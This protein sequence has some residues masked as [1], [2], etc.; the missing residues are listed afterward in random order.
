MNKKKVYFPNL[1]GLRFIAAFLVIIH[2]I[3]QLKLKFNLPNKYENPF[4]HISGRLGVLLFFVLSGFLITYLLLSE[5]EVTGSIA[6]KQFYIRRIL[7]IWPLYYLVVLLGLFVL[8]EISILEMPKYT[9]EV[10]DNFLLKITL[11]IFMLPN[12]ALVLLSPVP[13][14][15]QSWSIGVEEQ[16]YLIW[17][18][19]IKKS[20]KILLALILVILIYWGLR[21]SLLLIEFYEVIDTI[22]LRNTLGFLASFN[23]DCMAIGGITAYLYYHKKMTLLKFLYRKDLQMFVV[24]LTAVLVIFGVKIPYPFYAGLFAVIILNVATNP[25]NLISLENRPFNFLG[26]ISY[27]LYMYH[28]IAIALVLII[29][30]D[31]I[32]FNDIA[33]YFMSFTLAIIFASISYFFFE[34]RF[35]KLK[36]RF[37][38]IL[39]GELAKSE[40]LK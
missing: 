3:E 1:N 12:L 4:I 15:S 2:H 40:S 25:N 9:A 16:F 6:V 10:G 11:F 26:K 13:Y 36:G 19:I 7:R 39:S 34:E 31:T 5:K 27:G 24:L 33:I 30:K 32:L 18:N 22:L 17:P 37:S 14:I 20:S 28:S 8:P 38:T 29:V 23:I 21:I 35:I